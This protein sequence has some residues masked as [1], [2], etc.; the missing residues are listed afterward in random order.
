MHVVSRH[1]TPDPVN[2]YVNP[3][4]ISTKLGVVQ[5]TMKVYVFYRPP[6]AERVLV[7]HRVSPGPGVSGLT[8]LSDAGITRSHAGN[9]ATAGS[10]SASH[11]T[12]PVDDCR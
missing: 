7:F 6:W 12:R 3:G 5:V 1:A 10:H 9:T 4:M 2:P 8:V 11:P